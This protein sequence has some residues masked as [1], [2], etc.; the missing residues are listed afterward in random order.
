M[1]QIICDGF[2]VTGIASGIKKN[3]EL[4]LGL[5]YSDSPAN[6]AGVFTR[7]SVKAAPV[8]LTQKRIE[9][10]MA[11]AIIA[12]SGNANCCNG[13]R[14]DADAA[15]MTH[16]VAQALGI[17]DAAVLGAST[18][19]IGEPLPVH[20]IET[21]MPE[22][23]RSLNPR[24]WEDF[25]RAIMTT[26]KV[27]KLISRQEIF[28]GR[29]FTITAAAKGAGMIRPDMATMLCFIC[30]DAG[31]TASC[32]DAML[33][34][35]VDRSFNRITIDGDTSTNDTVLMMAN[36]RSGVAMDEP[37]AVD[38]FQ[39]VLDEMLVDLARQLVRDGEGVTKVVEIAVQNAVSPT[40][41]AAIADTVA[42]SLLVKTALFGADAN[43]GRI[44]GAAG[45][46]KAHFDPRCV[47]IYFNDVKMVEDGQGCGKLAE[48]EATQ[49]LK[50]REFTITLDLKAGDAS[51]SLLTCDLSLDYVR[52]NADY[53]S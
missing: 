2:T 26:D 24:G 5:I 51:C 19:V 45:R 6:V 42:H 13:S 16:C 25:A 21:A 44:I 41:A 39:A 22:L 52:I 48:S 23:K 53:R 35:A 15:A 29:P 11:Q 10:G 36:G 30:T 3:G 9:S 8:L 49:V 28:R 50:Q 1:T 27:P 40:D 14:G 34:S 20:K 4:D 46:S 33:R 38:F 18:G 47:D 17:S 43:W 31:A 12:N 7:N 37:A 32:L